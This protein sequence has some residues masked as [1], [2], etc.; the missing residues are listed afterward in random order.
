MSEQIRPGRPLA[1]SGGNPERPVF[2]KRPVT[3]ERPVFDER[4]VIEVG[5]IGPGSAASQAV[6]RRYLLTRAL[7]SSVVNAV[8]WTGVLVLLVAV[9][10]WLGHLRL[11]AVLVGLAALLIFAVRGLL[12]ALARRLSGASRLGPL[13]PRVAALVTRTR[14]GLRRELRRVGLPGV[15]W[16][17]LL[18][19]WRLLRPVRRVRTMAA[20]SR[21][22]LTKVVPPSQVD[23]LQILL[24]QMPPG[25]F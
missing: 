6:L 4:P 15:P 21:I 8:Q 10:C 16:G 12:N 18:I 5:N 22:D 11:L 19:A 13:E 3:K 9:L 23:E 1:P 7:G 17:P 14:K 24:R 20:L 25:R 2:V